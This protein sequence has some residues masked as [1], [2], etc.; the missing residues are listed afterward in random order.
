MG[1]IKKIALIFTVIITSLI[2]IASSILTL[3]VSFMNIPQPP[4]LNIST[5]LAD[6]EVKA[7]EISN[8]KELTQV[9]QSQKTALYDF[10]VIK[11]LLPLFSAI[12]GTIL[13]FIFV[14]SALDAY[15]IY[16]K[17]KFKNE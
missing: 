11:T 16:V 10:V 4:I 13:T 6:Q 9:L 7:K 12:I 5:T 1:D 17:S 8:Y 2:L 15:N 3:S 14:K